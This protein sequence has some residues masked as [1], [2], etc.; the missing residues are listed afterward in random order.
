[1]GESAFAHK[2]GMH[3]DGVDKVSRSYEHVDPESVGNARRFL[4]SEVSGKRAVLLKIADIAPD[5]TKN[6]RETA[7]IL[8]KLKELE[9]EGYQFEAADASFALMVTRV[10]GRFTPHFNLNMYKTSGEF[11]PPDGEMS[12]SALIKIE[13]GGR[14]ET[15]AALGNGPVNALDLALRKALCMF[16]PVLSDV[17]LVDFKVRVLNT[18]AA[19]GSRVRVLIESTD[20]ERRWTTVGASTDIIEASFI[21]LVDSLEYK[22]WMEER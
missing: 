16:Y 1:M 2:G 3:I 5:L 4:L 20:G 19:T 17:Y 11:P 18:G 15:T 10:L 7:E 8:Q 13:V 21:A 14:T 6:D 22:L 12:A 9:H